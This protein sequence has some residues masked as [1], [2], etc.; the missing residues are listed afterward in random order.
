VR[1]STSGSRLQP[2]LARRLTKVLQPYRCRRDGEDSRGSL[3]I[4]RVQRHA[5]VQQG[6]CADLETLVDLS[7][8]GC[9]L[10]APL[11]ALWRSSLGLRFRSSRQR[12]EGAGAL[13]LR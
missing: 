11:L 2:N 13:E 1:W 6:P 9:V 10:L 3:K 8:L 12:R 7:V 4:R 5:V